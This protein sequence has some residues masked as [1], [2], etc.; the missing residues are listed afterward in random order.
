MPH[1]NGSYVHDSAELRRHSKL[2]LMHILR[3]VS[4]VACVASPLFCGSINT[5]PPAGFSSNGLVPTVLTFSAGSNQIFGTNGAGANSDRDYVTFTVPSGLFLTAINRLDTTPLGSIGFLGLEAGN[6][7]TLPPST[8]TAAG[9]LGWRHYLLTD[10]NTDILPL[11]AVPANSSSG[12]TTPLPSG[13]YTLWIQDS[14]PGTFSYGFDVQLSAVPEPAT[15]WTAL[16]ALAGT[17]TLRR[18]RHSANN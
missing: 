12:F 4:I 6:Q 15:W 8:A 18:K 16:T 9:L 10:R 17:I 5:E 13:S 14:S 2:A 3:V 11:M 1:S 7:L